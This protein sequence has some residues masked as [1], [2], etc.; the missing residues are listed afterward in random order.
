MYIIIILYH[1]PGDLPL[2]EFSF[3]A[4]GKAMN[5]NTKRCFYFKGYAIPLSKR[6]GYFL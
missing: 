2:I 1:K 3:W 6:Q 4:R 5:F